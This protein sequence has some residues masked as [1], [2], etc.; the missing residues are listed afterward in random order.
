MRTWENRNKAPQ[1]PIPSTQLQGTIPRVAHLISTAERP[2]LIAGHG[3]LNNPKAPSLLSELSALAH[4]PV[5]TTFLGLGCFGETKAEALHMVGMH[6]AVYAN[7]AVQKADLILALGARLDERSASDAESFA[8]K[9]MEAERSSR[10]GIIQFDIEPE[11]VNKVVQVTEA[12]LG[13]L[14]DKLPRLISH[15]QRGTNTSHGSNKFKHGRG[16]IPSHP[17][18]KT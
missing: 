1:Q 7:Y 2:V 5:A 9:A 11:N 13:D 12:V 3:V 15:L 8:P 17:G 4:V 18:H 14:S 16:S 10:S 6:G